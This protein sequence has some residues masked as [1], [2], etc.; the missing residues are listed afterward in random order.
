MYIQMKKM[1]NQ[2]NLTE[3]FKDKEFGYGKYHIYFY[4]EDYEIEEEEADVEILDGLVKISTWE[5]DNNNKRD[6]ING[7]DYIP[8]EKIIR[9][10]FGKDF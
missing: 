3:M 4:S 9:I 2:K 7:Y 5:T 6:Y 10:S 1:F 8:F